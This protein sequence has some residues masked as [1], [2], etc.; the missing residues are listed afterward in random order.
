LVATC[1]RV[2]VLVSEKLILFISLAMRKAWIEGF[3]LCDVVCKQ[4][5]CF[6]FAKLNFMLEMK[7]YFYWKDVEKTTLSV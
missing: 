5:M 7:H 1:D 6:T 2:W 3:L 4:G